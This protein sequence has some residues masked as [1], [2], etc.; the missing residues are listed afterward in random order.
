MGARYS[1]VQAQPAAARFAQ[2][3]Q[4]KDN[5]IKLYFAGGAVLNGADALARMQQAAYAQF[6]FVNATAEELK[7][8][9]IPQ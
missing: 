9:P 2:V 8:K 5:D 4:D 6:G 3:P 7:L 1:G